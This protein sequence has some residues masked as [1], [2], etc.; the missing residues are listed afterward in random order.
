MVL[1][2]LRA[3]RPGISA[4]GA[5]RSTDG[6]DPRARAAGV[7]FVQTDA[8]R[9]GVRVGLARS[10][11]LVRGFRAFRRPGRA[12]DEA[13][14]VLRPGGH[15]YLLFGP[16]YTSPFGLHAYR[17]IPVPYC[18]YLFADADLRAYTR[19]ARDCR[20]LAV[21]QRRVG[22]Q[23]S[24]DFRG[25]ARGGSSVL[26][27]R[28][29]HRRRRRRTDHQVSL[30]LSSQGAVVRRS[31]GVGDRNLSPQAMSRPTSRLFVGFMLLA[32]ALAATQLVLF[33]D[34]L[35]G[36]DSIAY[37][38][39]A[40]QI[41][42]NWLCPCALAALVATLSALSARGQNDHRAA[43]RP[44]A[45]GHCCGRRRIARSAVRPRRSGVRL[46]RPLVLSGSRGF[47]PS[48]LASACGLSSV[49][50]LRRPAR[51][52]AFARCARDMLDRS[53]RLGLVAR[54]GQVS[55]FDGAR[56]PACSAA[57]RF[58]TRANLLHWSVVVGAAAVRARADVAWRAR[59]ATRT[60]S[61]LLGLLASVGPQTYV[62]SSARGQFTVWRVGQA[63]VRGNLRRG[64]A[65]RSSGLA[66]SRERRRRSHLHRRA[67]SELPGFYDP[68]REYDDASVP[69]RLTKAVLTVVRSVRATLFGYWSPSF[70][71]LWPLCWALW[72]VLMFGVTVFPC[73]LRRAELERSAALR[74]RLSWFL[75]ASGAPASRMH[76][77]SFSLGYYLPPYLIPLL[78]GLYLGMLSR[79]ADPV[80]ARVPRQRAVWI[81]AAGLV[82]RSC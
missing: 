66:G 37:F 27:S 32:V 59:R 17:Q 79:E 65:E 18:H 49:P 82:S 36:P 74:R 62:L 70:A 28:A 43:A 42:A 73:S 33:R 69:F 64:L 7:R 68:G 14:R 44:R 29:S 31:A 13:W 57:S 22:H 81:V 40:D 47:V 20:R 11:L 5:D 25:A 41:R 3:A 76:L 46:A 77:V 56:S 9:V 34:V 38:E 63:R 35:P 39:V 67:R 75:M 19:P 54:N 80:T 45:G 53:R 61:S 50:V 4:Y 78:M 1:A 60:A 48:W 55:I 58:S 15:L 30:V 26:L 23:L 52:P 72:P 6:I 24:S 10:R 71:L 51:R 16:V 12:V 2:A 21:R 8:S